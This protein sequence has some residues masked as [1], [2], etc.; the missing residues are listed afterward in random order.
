V[1][2]LAGDDA[3]TLAERVLH[4]EHRLLV[5]TLRELGAR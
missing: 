1:P 4:E 2:V 5:A 3:A